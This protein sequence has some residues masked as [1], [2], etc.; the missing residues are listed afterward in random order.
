MP[1]RR[2]KLLLPWQS[3]CQ[4]AKEQ[5]TISGFLFYLASIRANSGVVRELMRN[6]GDWAGSHPT[7]RGCL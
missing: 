7:K 1:G 2:V 6:T 4:A 3:G 5:M